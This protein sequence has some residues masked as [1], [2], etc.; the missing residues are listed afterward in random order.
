LHVGESGG[1]IGRCVGG[2]SERG[3][4]GRLWCCDEDGGSGVEAKPWKQEV[5]RE[6][7]QQS[8]KLINDET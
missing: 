2:G 3:V 6:S 1:V 5:F 4:V 8:K 7:Q